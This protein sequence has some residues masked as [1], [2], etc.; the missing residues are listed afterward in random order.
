MEDEQM[1]EVVVED[2]LKMPF[3]DER[4]LRALMAGGS[5]RELSDL[6]EAGAD[7]RLPSVAVVLKEEGGVRVLPVWMGLS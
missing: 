1:I 6:V 5:L 3:D 7:L 4:G 2:A